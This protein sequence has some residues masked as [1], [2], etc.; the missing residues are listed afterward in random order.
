MDN[1]SGME[2]SIKTTG[3]EKLAVWGTAERGRYVALAGKLGLT[4]PVV[5]DWV[6][7]KKRIPAEQCPRIEELTGIKCEDL[8]PDVRWDVLRGNCAHVEKAA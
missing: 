6:S 4:A 3:A 7:G 5:S 1:N 8:R 2:T